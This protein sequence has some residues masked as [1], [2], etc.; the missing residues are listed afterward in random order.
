MKNVAGYDVARL[1]AGSLGTLGLIAEV[2]LKVLPRPVTE[3]TRELEMAEAE[4]IE[5]MNRWAGEPLPVSATLWERGRLLVRLSGSEPAVR[6]AAL[7]IGGAPVEDASIWQ[8]VREH[9]HAFF[10]GAHP[11]WRIAVPSTTAPLGLPGGTLI[12]WNGA[13]RWVRGAE[14][15]EA[16]RRA[17]GHAALFRGRERQGVFAPLDPV[18]MDLHRRLKE[19]FD[20]AGILNP[21]RMYPEL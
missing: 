4:A 15:R 14:P 6:G 7:K 1:A 20:P 12:E 21:G 3:A 10:S 5:T 9:Q 17:G 18:L 19:A 8:E 16:V 11:L 13:Q 2:S